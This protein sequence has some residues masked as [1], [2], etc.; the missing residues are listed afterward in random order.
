MERI[1]LAD[2]AAFQAGRMARH[3]LAATARVQADLYCLQ[4]GQAQAP[5][6]HADQDK[7]Y[8]GVE[9]R[10]RIRVGEEAAWIDPG[11]LVVAPAGMEHGVENPTQGP[12]ILLVVVVPPPPLGGG[13]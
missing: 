2:R 12:C 7:L 13:A 8:L 4:P 10:A 5:H 1:P 11:V 9:G 6:A 3:R